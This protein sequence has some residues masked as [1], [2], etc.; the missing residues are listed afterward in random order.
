MSK[1]IHFKGYFPLHLLSEGI[2]VNICEHLVIQFL[3][4]WEPLRP[5]CY[6]H[7]L[8]GL[9]CSD[10]QRLGHMQS[11]DQGG[12][13]MGILLCSEGSQTWSISWGYCHH[14]DSCGGLRLHTRSPAEVLLVCWFFS[15][16][17][18]VCLCLDLWACI[19]VNVCVSSCGVSVAVR[20]QV[21]S[22]FSWL[23]REII[24]VTALNI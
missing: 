3:L 12:L 14:L 20:W 24:L 5:R 16:H 17:L 9:F 22:F 19:N 15:E 10:R 7:C 23:R 13:L 8:F 1:N 18:R 21:W 4:F 11:G 6:C 2:S